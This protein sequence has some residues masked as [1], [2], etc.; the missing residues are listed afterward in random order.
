[1][2]KVVEA[3]IPILYAEDEKLF[4]TMG[5]GGLSEAVSCRVLWKINGLYELEM[6]YPVSGRRFAELKSR[7]IIWAGVGPDEEPQP[8][9]I[10]HI[11]KP[12]LGLCKIFA[13]HVVYDL[14]GYTVRP[15]TAEGLSAALQQLQSG[16]TVQDHDFEIG[17][18]MASG[19]VCTADTPR[20]VWSML[21]GQ[22]GS[23]LDTYGGEWLFDG[24]SASLRERLGED[25]GVVVRYG[26]NLQTL[27]QDENLAN[28]WTAVQPY[29]Y[30]ELEGTLVT[31]P[32]ETISAG[33]F[34][35]TRVL[36]LDLSG[37][38]AE[39]PTEEQLRTRA[40]RYISD[41]HVG[42]PS[43]GLDI[44]FIPLNQTEEY[45]GRGFLDKIHKGDT[46]WVEF[47]TS[48]DPKTGAPRAFVQTSARAV[49]YVWLPI[50]EKYE[51]VRIGGVKADFVDAVAQL[52]KDVSW[53][54]TQVR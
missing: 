25:L 6:E 12:I 30:D 54:M 53:V 14:M 38:F 8:F 45:K 21:G 7:R 32:E 46:V 24:Y 1:M 29:W 2:A 51:S 40:M 39:P 26:K 42:E 3:V 18:D 23:L 49:Q 31:L 36:T 9:R 11:R 17:T 5:F 20:S 13:R 19:A 41:N 35:Y 47:P 50:E 44:S 10:Y 34:D 4:A 43:V 48:F 28:C 52:Q 27:E 15:F 37:E 33:T 22:R 16:A